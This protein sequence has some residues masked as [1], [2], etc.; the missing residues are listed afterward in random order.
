[1]GNNDFHKRLKDVRIR[2]TDPEHE[3]W[4]AKARALGLSLSAWLRLRANG[5]LVH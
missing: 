4:T 3:T 2:A 1:M 5:E